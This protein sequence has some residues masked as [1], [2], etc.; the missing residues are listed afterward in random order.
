M[1]KL[2]SIQSVSDI[3][4]NSSSEVFLLKDSEEVIKVLDYLGIYYVCFKTWDDIRK[5]VEQN[6]YVVDDVMKLS[7]PYAHCLLIEDLEQFHTKDEIWEFFK[8]MYKELLGSVYICVDN[9]YLYNI[10][11]TE[12]QYNMFKSILENYEIK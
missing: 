8:P 11:N 10:V 3:I 9:N 12:E 5:E 6:N 7:N 4:T 2:I 1:K